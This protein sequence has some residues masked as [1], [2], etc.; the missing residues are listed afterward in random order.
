MVSV[1]IYQFYLRFQLALLV[2]DHFQVFQMYYAHRIKTW[3]GH[4]DSTVACKTNWAL[5][6]QY[7]AISW[8]NMFICP[9]FLL[10][11]HRRFTFPSLATGD[12][13]ML[14]VVQSLHGDTRYLKWSVQRISDVLFIA[15]KRRPCEK[16]FVYLTRFIRRKGI[17]CDKEI[18]QIYTEVL[19][20]GWDSCLFTMVT[21]IWFSD[22]VT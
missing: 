16:S 18:R 7:Q 5:I 9:I 15:Q 11:R 8:Q 21:R 22:L 6:R 17:I 3:T 13:D 20:S 1:I 2:P 12:N 4:Q 10:S 19:N 14:S